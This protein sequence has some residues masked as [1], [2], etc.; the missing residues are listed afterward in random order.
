M[1]T[2]EKILTDFMRKHY[3]DEKLAAL[4]AHA[5]DEKL[6]YF[7]CCCFIGVSTA[8]HALRCF[9]EYV[10][11]INNSGE[12]HYDT[13]YRTNDGD[14]ADIAYCN[15]AATDEEDDLKADAERRERIIPLIKAEM[16]RRQCIRESKQTSLSVNIPPSG[17]VP[18]S[19]P[20]ADAVLVNRA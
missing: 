16:N 14:L 19:V 10:G 2:N 17:V 5:E 13:A 3:T 6:S 9:G 1:L 7:S 15:L 11:S 4:L 18:V 12:D 8:D 20:D